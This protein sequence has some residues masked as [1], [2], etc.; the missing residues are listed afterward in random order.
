MQLAY[1]NGFAQGR[2]VRCRRIQQFLLGFRKRDVERTLAT[3]FAFNQKPE[4]DGRLSGTRF[5]FQLKQ[6]AC[7]QPSCQYVIQAFHSCGY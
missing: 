6:G 7:G 3:P 1:L 4:R 5:P 2:A